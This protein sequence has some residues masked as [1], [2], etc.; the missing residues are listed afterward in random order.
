MPV[1]VKSDVRKQDI[2]EHLAR[3]GRLRAYF[4]ERG[5]TRKLQGAIAGMVFSE[6]MQQETMAA[7]LYAIVPSGDTSVIVER[8]QGWRPREW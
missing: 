2:A 3:I 8:P 1:E 5:D 4:D 6:D 7:G